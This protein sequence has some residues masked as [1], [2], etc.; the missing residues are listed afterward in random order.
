MQLNLF[1]IHF[2]RARLNQHWSYRSCGCLVAQVEEREAIDRQS[3][4]A[5]ISIVPGSKLSAEV[6]QNKY[7]WEVG[8]GVVHAD[9]ESKKQ[10]MVIGMKMEAAI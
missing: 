4:L 9:S 3:E 8:S 6:N 1:A 5:G 10:G 2:D 7:D